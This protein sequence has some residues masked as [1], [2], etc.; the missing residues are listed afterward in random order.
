MVADD[1]AQLGVLHIGLHARQVVEALIA[2]GLL[3]CLFCR[4]HCRK[5]GRQTAG[6]HHLSLGIARMHAYTF[7]IYL[8]AGG[9][10]VLKL[11]F[12]HVAA[13]HRVGPVT[14]ELLHIKV[15]GTHADLLVRIE[16]D[17]DVAM[18]HFRVV[19]QPA[20]C[21]DDFCNAR[22]VVST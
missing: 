13:V 17:A 12:A 20:H 3:W 10:E 18:L 19:S 22:L 9:V 1:V 7:Y 2:L 16:G 6:V 5:L 4:Q 11:Q 21:L 14:T 15:M 8:S